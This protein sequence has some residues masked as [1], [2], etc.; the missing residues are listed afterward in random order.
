[1]AWSVVVVH[2]LQ[3]TTQLDFVIH[4]MCCSRM[5]SE[6]CLNFVLAPSPSSPKQ[7]AHTEAST[8]R[9]W[10]V[11]LWVNLLM[12]TR[13]VALRASLAPKRQPVWKGSLLAR[14]VAWRCQLF[15][16][17]LHD[18]VKVGRHGTSSSVVGVLEGYVAR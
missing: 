2:S 6:A 9:S 16:D 4:Q 17:L 8:P 1:M 13:A 14:H 10:I 12:V 3:A 11:R 15:L 7:V 5:A 18:L